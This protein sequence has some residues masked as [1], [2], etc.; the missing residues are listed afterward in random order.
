LFKQEGIQAS[1]HE[2]IIAPLRQDSDD[3]F[4]KFF[5]EQLIETSANDWLPLNEIIDNYASYLGIKF[6]SSGTRRSVKLHLQNRGYLPE[7][8]RQGASRIVAIRGLQPRKHYD[9]PF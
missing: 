2:Q 5:Q 4:Q 1:I 8:V 9:C 3:S 6:A 7:R